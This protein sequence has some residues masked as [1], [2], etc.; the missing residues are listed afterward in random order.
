MVL[1]EEKRWR[2]ENAAAGAI[3][4]FTTVASLHPLDVIRTRFQVSDGRGSSVPQYN[5]TAHAIFSIARYEGVRGLYAGFYPAVFGS[6]VSW[7]LYFFFYNRAKQRYS[8]RRDDQLSPA[9]HLV[10]AAEA[11]AL[12][13]LC[14]NPIWLVKT[15]LQLQVPAN[16]SRPYSGFYDAMRTILKEEGWLAL[17]RGLGPSLFLVTHGAIQFTVY[18]ELKKAVIYVK[19]REIK[20]NSLGGEELLSSFDYATLGAASKVAAMLFTYPYQVI[21]TRLQQRP[22]TD[23]VPKYLHSW[24]VVKET[25]RFEGF[26]GFYKGMTSNLLKNIPAASITFVVYENVLKLIQLTRDGN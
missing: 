26:R 18:E 3:A 7:G 22:S 21:R 8:R 4:G 2:W 19:R 15:R 5:N 20:S 13:S 12:V 23:G 11:G 9:Y 16:H 17:Y 10:S 6:T 24:H 1:A 14:T 25:T